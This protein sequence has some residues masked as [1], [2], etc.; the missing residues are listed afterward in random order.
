MLHQAVKQWVSLRRLDQNKDTHKILTHTIGNV[1]SVALIIHMKA[2]AQLRV[3]N[4]ERVVEGIILHDAVVTL[5]RIH[6]KKRLTQKRMKD[7]QE[8]RKIAVQLN[9]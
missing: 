4:V 3:K 6:H 1:T 5:Q 7:T 2:N 8:I 9:W